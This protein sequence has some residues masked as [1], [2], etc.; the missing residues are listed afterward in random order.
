MSTPDTSRPLLTAERRERISALL[1]QRRVV[2]VTELSQIFDVSEVTIR[3]DL[4]A[5]AGAGQLQRSRGGALAVASP[6]LFDAFELRAG[7]NLEAKRR[8]GRAAAD[9]VR[10]HDRV[11]L[12]SGTTVMEMAKCLH[13]RGPLTVV[14]NALNVA[15]EVG[16]GLDIDVVLAGG[17]LHRGNICTFGPLAERVLADV[18]VHKVFLGTYALDPDVGLADLSIEQATIKQAM[19]RAGRQVILL[20]DSSKWG[21]E[22]FAKV[23]PLSS[24]HTIVSDTNLPSS[25]RVAMERLGIEVLLV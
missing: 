7:V 17:S 13:D 5:M 2:R 20:A 16:V 9:L 19:T 15:T 14:T 12:D 8:I 4:D 22:G 24:V 6:S 21:T 23:L 11:I 10:P 3:S 18:M 1:R 25:A